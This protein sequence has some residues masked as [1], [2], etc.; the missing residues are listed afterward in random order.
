MSNYVGSLEL[1]NPQGA[2]PAERTEN[3]RALTVI[4]GSTGGKISSIFVYN[5]TQTSPRPVTD[6]VVFWIGGQVKPDEMIEGDFWF[7]GDTTPEVPVDPVDPELPVTTHKVFGTGE[8]SQFSGMTHQKEPV[9]R[10]ASGF[11]T[12]AGGE[13]Y[14]AIGMRIW[15]PEGVTTS[16]GNAYLYASNGSDPDLLSPTLTK[17][18]PVI[19]SSGWHDVMFATPAQMVPGIPVY[20]GYEFADGTYMY[21]TGDPD[22]TEFIPPLDGSKIY[23][24]E[25]SLGGIFRSYYAANG[26]ATTKSISSPFYGIDIITDEG[27]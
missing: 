6:S 22:Y 1:E 9:L 13:T 8:P 27:A 21:K 5:A 12:T 19:T 26:G 2:R 18:I 16:T 14:R 25:G 24:M 11:Y 17:A 15:I 3:A 10:V 20:V 23:L 4:H 7:R